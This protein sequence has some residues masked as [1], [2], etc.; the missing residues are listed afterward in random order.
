M[1]DEE[2]ETMLLKDPAFLMVLL[3]AILRKNGGSL[4]F[5]D[6]EIS[7]VTTSD[8]LGLYKDADDEDCFVLKLV[9]SDDYKKYVM[10][11]KAK[12]TGRSATIAP[13]YAPYDGVD[14][15]EWEN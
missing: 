12:T 4:R 3:A 14:D 9:D 7:A 11:K 8:A 13:K 6:D 1:R 15:D 10:D 5:T 2:S